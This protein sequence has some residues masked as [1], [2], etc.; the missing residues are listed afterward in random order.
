MLVAAGVFV[1]VAMFYRGRT[2][3]QSQE[4]PLEETAVE[5][6]LSSGAPT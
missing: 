3:L 1:V 4:L 6:L 5:P 2:Y